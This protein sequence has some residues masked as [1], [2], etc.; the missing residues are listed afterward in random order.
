MNDASELT[1]KMQ[2]KTNLKQNNMTYPNQPQDRFYIQKV[3]Q[4]AFQA[5]FES[6]IMQVM[7]TT[8]KAVL[9]NVRGGPQ[10]LQDQ[11]SIM[12]TPM[13]TG[14]YE[15]M[16]S[17]GLSGVL[18]VVFEILPFIFSMALQ[19]IREPEEDTIE[20]IMKRLGVQKSVIIIRDFAAAMV[21]ALFWVII[22]SFAMWFSVFLGKLSLGVIITFTILHCLQTG[23]RGIII[24]RLAPGRAQFLITVTIFML[25][26]SLS[27]V[28]IGD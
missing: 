18:I 4:T 25:Q 16:E 3:S 10:D 9:K 8:T 22:A 20:L 15:I 11:F 5:W 24:N 17:D 21:F 1:F 28:L 12:Y 6:D 14:E 23:L 7:A 19:N 26:I 13:S 2:I 27:P